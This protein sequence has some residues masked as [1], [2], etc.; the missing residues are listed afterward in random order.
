[1]G[2][3]LCESKVYITLIP[4]NKPKI[5]LKDIPAVNFFNVEMKDPNIW[6]Q[7]EV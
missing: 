7:A 1:M 5:R 3:K 6:K 2:P 4:N